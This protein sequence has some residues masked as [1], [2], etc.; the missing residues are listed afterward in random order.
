MN[1]LFVLNRSNGSSSLVGIGGND[2]L[3]K[4][5]T[6]IVNFQAEPIKNLEINFTQA[7]KSLHS[8]SPNFSLDYKD[9]EAIQGTS[10]N[11]NQF[12]SI[13]TTTYYPGRKVLGHGVETH[14]NADRLR[15]ITLQYTK[16]IKGFLNSDFNYSKLHFSYSQPWF[17]GGFGKMKTS[18]QLGKTFGNVPLALLNPVPG[19]QSYFSY[20]STFNQL[21]FYEFVTDTYASFHMQHNF[22]GRI[23]SRIPLLRKLNLRAIVGFKSVIGNLSQGN[24]DLNSTNHPSQITFRTPSK[25][26]YYEYSFGIGNIFKILQIDFNFRGNYLNI[27]NARKSGITFTTGLNF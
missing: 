12:E 18:I 25:T 3:T 16:G 15:N 7:Y 24:I 20:Y 26:P 5:K 22:N 13:F 2:K 17:I 10:S 8:A 4:V 9:P 19:N 23:F 11:I 27:P 14:T 1:S 21:D 6:S